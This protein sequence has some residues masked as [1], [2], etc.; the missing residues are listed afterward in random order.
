MNTNM[1]P[2]AT[3]TA[4]WTNSGHAY[5]ASAEIVKVNR[6]TV[7]V[8]LVTAPDGYTIGRVMTLDIAKSASN[9]VVAA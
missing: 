9:C 7:R 6:E 8:R 3:V 5:K 4:Y 1:K 2:G